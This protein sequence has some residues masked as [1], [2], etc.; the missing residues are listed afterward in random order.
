MK[1]KPGITERTEHEVIVNTGLPSF[2][3]MMREDEGTVWLAIAP[4]GRSRPTGLDVLEPSAARA[5]ARDLLS[6]ADQAEGRASPAS[7]PHN[8]ADGASLTD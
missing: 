4:N 5:I 8:P 7:E 2:S 1:L 6:L 3:L